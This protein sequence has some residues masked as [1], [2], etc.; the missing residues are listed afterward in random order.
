[1]DKRVLDFIIIGI[2]KKKK[3][4]YSWNIPIFKFLRIFE[5]SETQIYF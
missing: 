4:K 1:L 3:E 5:K 2:R